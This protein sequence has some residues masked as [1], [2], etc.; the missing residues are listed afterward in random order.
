MM[1]SSKPIILLTGAT[2]T[3][4]TNIS[5]EIANSLSEKNIECEIVNGDSLLFYKELSI[6]T[7]KPNSGELSQVPHHLIDTR[8]ITEPM[9]ASDYA[10]EAWKIID[11][12][13]VQNKIPL[14]TGGS[15]F[16]VRALIKGLYEGES[17]APSAIDKVQ[18][19]ENEEGWEKIR[20]LLKTHDPESFE[21]LHENDHYRNRRALEFYYTTGKKFSDSKKDKEEEGPYDFSRP[22]K[23]DWKIHHAYLSLPKDQHWKIMDLRVAKMLKDGLLEEVENLLLKGFNPDLKPLQSI[24]YKECIDL[25]NFLKTGQAEKDKPTDLV[26]LRERIYINTRRLAKS[27]KTFFKK[28][29]P[30]ITYNSLKDKELIVQDCLHFLAPY[31][32]LG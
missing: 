30:K 20:D 10:Q 2:A 21:N 31:T 1:T 24:G 15:A 3:G 19:I 23:A 17:S 7:A 5:L 22:L 16:Y 9:N 18:K 11:N 12:L 4:K 8:S 13:H 6:G 27:Q 26:S 32:D 14:V 25:I 28:I 29:E